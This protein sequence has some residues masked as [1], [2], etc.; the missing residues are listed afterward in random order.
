MSATEFSR[1]LPEAKELHR[2]IGAWGIRGLF[3]AGVRRGRKMALGC[4]RL[5]RPS[6]FTA[7]SGVS[8]GGQTIGAESPAGTEVGD[9]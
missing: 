1:S 4:L 8:R 6:V 2:G 3:D 5:L 9:A 7:S